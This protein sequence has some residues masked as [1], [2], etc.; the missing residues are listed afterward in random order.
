MKRV[1][2]MRFKEEENEE[3]D[4][5]YDFIKISKYKALLNESRTIEISISIAKNIGKL[6]EIKTIDFD[7][8]VKMSLT[9]V[10]EIIEKTL[11]ECLKKTSRYFLNELSS[12]HIYHR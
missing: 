7:D 12:G 6:I 4:V 11:N 8:F 5:A 2:F 10:N 1:D 9:E 3:L